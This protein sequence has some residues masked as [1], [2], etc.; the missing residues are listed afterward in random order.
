MKSSPKLA[1][2]FAVPARKPSPSPTSSSSDP[3]P[4]AIPN[5]VRK[6]RSLCV[7]MARNTSPRLSKN[8][9]IIE[10]RTL[11][12]QSSYLLDNTAMTAVTVWSDAEHVRSLPTINRG[13]PEY[14]FFL[15]PLIPGPQSLIPVAA[16][17][18]AAAG[19]PAK[20]KRP[21][22]AGL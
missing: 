20:V 16:P 13:A 5:M 15:T 1:R 3:T 7:H 12:H 17:T 19:S 2:F 18:P 6:E 11:D 4:Q 8:R 14:H 9:L 21:G 22:G 10:V